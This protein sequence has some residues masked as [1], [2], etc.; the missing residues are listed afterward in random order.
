MKVCKGR[1]L[2]TAHAIARDIPSRMTGKHY[3]AL[4]CQISAALEQ[5]L[6]TRHTGK[7]TE[8]GDTHKSKTIDEIHLG[9]DWITT[10]V[11]PRLRFCKKTQHNKDYDNLK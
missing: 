3:K 5:M 7:V 4:K 11:K 10:V 2:K 1:A 6:C 9:L 8:P